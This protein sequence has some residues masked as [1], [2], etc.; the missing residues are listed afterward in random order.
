MLDA[1]GDGG[2]TEAAG[3]GGT[4]GSTGDGSTGNGGGGGILR[5][6]PRVE[7][8]PATGQSDLAWISSAPAIPVLAGS[9]VP[10]GFAARLAV[11]GTGEPWAATVVVVGA[12]GAVTTTTAQAAAD[13]GWV[14]DI[15]SGARSVWV[16][17]SQ[18]SVRAGLLVESTDPAGPLVTATPLLPLPVTSTTVPV[19]EVRH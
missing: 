2:A 8:R 18:G 13:T 15:P 3:D 17:P 16:R 19:R 4:T 1:A 10:T 5:A 14:G 9:P 6:E 7:R 12:D 11:V